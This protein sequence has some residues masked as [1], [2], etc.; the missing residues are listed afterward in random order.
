MY[1][2]KEAIDFLI[3]NINKERDL[4]KK[5]I[6]NLD[7]TNR[8]IS[9]K[10]IND[11]IKC[12]EHFNNLINKN[13]SEIMTYI[14][15]LNED[16]I[17]QFVSYSRKFGSIIGLYNKTGKDNFSEV[18]EIVNN[19]SLI[20][21]LD[22]ED[23]CYTNSEGVWIKIKNIEELIELKSKINLQPKQKK[24]EKNEIKVEKEKD[25]YEDKFDKDHFLKK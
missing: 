3:K 23:F 18:Y 24:E 19:A 6:K 11:T 5:L 16:E 7:P 12:L 25:E 17:K 10:D 20:F 1:D 14:K 9:I 22:G 21:N 15:S 2:K 4:R 8:S 13:S